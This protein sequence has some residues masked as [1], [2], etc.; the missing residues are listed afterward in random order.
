M[1]DQDTQTGGRKEAPLITVGNPDLV[2]DHQQKQIFT[3]E[4]VGYQRYSELLTGFFVKCIRWQKILAAEEFQEDDRRYG[5]SVFRSYDG[6]SIKPGTTNEENDPPDKILQVRSIIRVDIPD[7]GKYGAYPEF[8]K[9]RAF[10]TQFLIRPGLAAS[11]LLVDPEDGQP[12]KRV[13]ISIGLEETHVSMKNIEIRTERRD[14]EREEG[15]FAYRSAD[16]RLSKDTLEVQHKCSW[17]DVMTDEMATSLINTIDSLIPQASPQ[18]PEPTV[19]GE[20]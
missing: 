4:D 20:Q 8:R 12:L 7:F 18:L 5:F 6:L 1:A 17:F 11:H 13:E 19:E 9:Y 15:Y 10:R 16:Y 14:I 3:P 2:S